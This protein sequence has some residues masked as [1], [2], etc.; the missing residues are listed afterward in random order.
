MYAF[1]SRPISTWRTSAGVAVD[2]SPGST[3]TSSFSPSGGVTASVA[4]SAAM[5]TSTTSVSL[6]PTGLHPRQRE[7]RMGQRGDPLGVVGEPGEEV[8]A[9]LSVVLGAGAQ[10]LDRAGD[11]GERIA[12]LVRGVG[13]E[14]A[15]GELATQLLGPVAD[16]EPG[17]CPRREAAGAAP[18]RRGRRP[19]ARHSQPRPLGRALERRPQ[20]LERWPSGFDQ[21]LGRGV[22]E[23]HVAVG[24]TTITASSAVENRREVVALGRRA[25]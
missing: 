22:G 16:D 20:R 15:L 1:V 24:A 7:Q 17:L 10:D 21:R 8:L 5:P 25:C 3:S 13:D 6:P 23:A 9:R 12:Q 18:R 19:A 2:A 14:V 4:S 11:P